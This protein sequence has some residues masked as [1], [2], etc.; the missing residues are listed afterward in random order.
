LLIA[1]IQANK[2]SMSKEKQRYENIIEAYITKFGPL[3]ED[4]SNGQSKSEVSASR[5]NPMELLG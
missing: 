1:E 3:E 4:C 5:I 2:E